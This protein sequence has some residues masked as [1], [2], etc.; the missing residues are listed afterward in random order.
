[1]HVILRTRAAATLAVLLAGWPVL[2]WYALR[3]TDGSDEPYGLLALAAAF[4]FAPWR[5]WREPL[6]PRQHAWLAAGLFLYA[7][8]ALCAPPLGRA[9]VLVGVLAGAT[10]PRGHA[11][12][13]TTLLALSLPLLATLQFYLGYPLRALT[14]WLC[15]PLL[16]LG[17]LDVRALGTTLLWAGERVVV[18]TPCSGLRMAWTGLF[19]AAVLACAHRLST[20]PAW[21]LLR[22]AAFLIFVAN[23]LRAAVLFCLETGVWA[24]PSWAHESVGLLLF[25]AAAVGLLL[26][27]EPPATRPAAYA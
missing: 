16:Q 4:L 11:L 7:G 8:A 15:V 2:R 13:W 14:A 1:M 23:V 27:A 10:A 17:G 22:R 3:L 5:A 24:N 9:L 18:D 19:L 25:A 26:T 21:A 20:R 12:A 6:T